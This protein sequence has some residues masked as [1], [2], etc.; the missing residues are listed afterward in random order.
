MATQSRL[1]SLRKTPT[2][3]PRIQAKQSDAVAEVAN[4]NMSLD[5]T[6]C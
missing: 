6:N 3:Q 5:H 1:P 4:M 2:S